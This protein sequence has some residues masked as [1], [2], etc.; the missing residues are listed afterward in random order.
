[1]DCPRIPEI[2]YTEWSKTFHEKASKRIPI[3]GSLELTFRCNNNCVH[4]Y[5]NK[6]VNDQGEIAKELSTQEV[7]RILDEIVDEGCL[8]FLITGG[9]PL[10]RPDFKDI[11]LYAKRKG[12]LITL[13]TNGT[14]I[15]EEM[16]DLL[17]EWRPYSVEIT[18]YGMTEATYEKITRVPNSYR[19]CMDGINRLVG[20]NITLELKTMAMTLNLHE[21]WDMKRYA[22]SLGLKF[23]FDPILNLRLDGEKSPTFYRL[24]TDEVVRLDITDGERLKEWLEFCDKY[25]FPPESDSLYTCGAGLNSFHI[26]PYGNLSPCILARKER[27][28]LN[29]GSF[30][31]GWYDFIGSLREKTLSSDTRCKRCELISLCGQCPGWSQLEHGDDESPVDYLCDIA[32][33]RAEAFGVNPVR[34]DGALTPPFL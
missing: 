33:K 19:R 27:Y 2:S 32:Q 29:D 22:E 17:S 23:R 24:S 7:F 21:L 18:L 14:L 30:K 8:W 16:T 20:E 12:L 13:F 34:K 6:S 9:E 15:T 5:C 28:D 26:D 3:S 25:I 31:E 11:Y 1:M 10:L 4:C